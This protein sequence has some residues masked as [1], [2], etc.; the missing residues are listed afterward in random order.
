MSP[1]HRISFR[2]SKKLYHAVCV[3]LTASNGQERSLRILSNALGSTRLANAWHTVEKYDDTFPFATYKIF[4]MLILAS[5][6]RSPCRFDA[7]RVCL[8]EA[9]HHLLMLWLQY[10]VIEGLMVLFKWSNEIDIKLDCITSVSTLHTVKA[11]R[12]T[13]S[14]VAKDISPDTSR[15]K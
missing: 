3:A 15:E 6:D 5:A 1:V 9:L 7:R 11:W 10:Q 2:Q 14:A 4:A 8:H 12:H 13:P